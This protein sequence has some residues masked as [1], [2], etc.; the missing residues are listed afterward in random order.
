MSKTI[1]I[2]GSTDGIGLKTAEKLLDQGHTVLLHGRNEEKLQ[3]TYDKF[4][5]A[6]GNASV[7]KYC[8]DLSD[9]TQVKTLADE[10]ISK[11]T[12]IDA[13]INN[14]GVYKVP[15]TLT[16]NGL[17]IRFVVNTLAPYLL[18][19]QLLPCLTEASRVINLSSAAQAP[20][21]LQALTG[22][23]KLGDDQAYAQSKLAITMWSF[24][25]AQTLSQSPV[26]VAVNPA[27]FLGSKMVKEA[28]G[29][30][31]HD[32]SIG[33]DILVRAAT[34]EEFNNASGTYY[35]NDRRQFANP[36]PDALDS[37]KNAELVKVLDELLAS[38]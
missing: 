12:H 11:H 23:K 33:A 28:Y 20:V 38:D 36:H 16:P 21:D 37:N 15:Q 5:A 7:E 29:V 34:S 17:D 27:S 8:A 2:T 22:G 18:T 1:L 31:G 32:L 9:L 4:V 35:D 30:S 6:H 14:A 3:S 19:R 25:L 13:V 26:I 10:L 24:H